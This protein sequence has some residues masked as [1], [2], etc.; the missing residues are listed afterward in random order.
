MTFATEI[1]RKGDD[2]GNRMAVRYTFPDGLRVH[3]VGVPQAW[4]SPL[5]PTWCYVVEGDQLT[6]I[7][8]GCN[9]SIGQL[10]EG[11]QAIGHSL[12]S[13]D[14]IIVTHGHLDHDG[15]CYH[16]SARTGA[17]IWAH[18]VY[19]KLIRLSRWEIETHWRRSFPGFPQ[20][21]DDGF[22]GRIKEHEHL[23]RQLPAVNPV[24]D[25][26]CVGDFRFFYTPGHSPDELCI[27]YGRV[28]FSGDHI[29]PQV[30]PHPSV[31]LSYQRFREEL[32]QGFRNGN[33]YYGL[34]V[35][36][37]SLKKVQ[38]LGADITVLP[39]HRAYFGGKFNVTG[40]ERAEEI[41]EHHRQRCQ[42]L[43]GLIGGGTPDLQTVT[44]KHFSHIGLEGGNFHLAFTEVISHLEFLSEVGDVEM[45]VGDGTKVRRRGSENF[46]GVIDQL[47]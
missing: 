11:L 42:D 45:G 22:E 1:I 26:Q 37:K 44:R 8:P 41:I 30:T 16:L 18:E 4:N 35:F 33:D 7:D 40:L 29:L 34:R 19:G 38:G 28:M 43:L 25:R 46:S 20:V 32:A 36:L 2:S 21:V 12:E 14:R 27:Q 17:E 15:N 5:G 39:A 47:G 31:A 23:V 9:G 13:V 10:E 6:V 24:T 3:A